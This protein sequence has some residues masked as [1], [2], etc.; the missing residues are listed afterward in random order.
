MAAAA[1]ATNTALGNTATY[2]GNALGIS[3]L[4]M[5][6]GSNHKAI[7]SGE[8]TADVKLTATFHNTSPTVEGTMN[9][10]KGNAVGSDWS[11]ELK[12]ASLLNTYPPA[13]SQ[14]G[15]ARGSGAQHDG[16]WHARAHNGTAAQ[17]HMGIIGFFRTFFP[18][19]CAV[20]GYATV[21]DE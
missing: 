1:L 18:N 11:V 21:K 12:E 16:R 14:F 20:G 8:F 10:F 7:K 17:R 6:D 9:N 3:V 5:P 4:T 15:L 19:G 13:S 2:S